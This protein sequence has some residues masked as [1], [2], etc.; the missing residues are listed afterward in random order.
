M[1]RVAGS[2]LR[3]SHLCPSVKRPMQTHTALRPVVAY[4]SKNKTEPVQPRIWMKIFVLTDLCPFPNALQYLIW[5]KRV[6]Q[7][8]ADVVDRDDAEEDHQAGEDR[9]PGIFDE[10]ILCGGDQIAP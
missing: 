6:T 4:A 9:Q 8:V 7:T 1:R 10:V 3:V 5:I 2:Q